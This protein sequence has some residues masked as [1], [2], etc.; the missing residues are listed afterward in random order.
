MK[1]EV[2]GEQEGT[3]E[4]NP[5]AEGSGA[6]DGDARVEPVASGG[7]AA[8][9]LHV[10]E[11][12]G[13]PPAQE[14]L[15]ED[16]TEAGAVA[17][18][19]QPASLE[20]AAEVEPT[21]ETAAL[22]EEGAMASAGALICT[23]VLPP[24]EEAEEAP[25]APAAVPPLPQSPDA[26]PA[27]EKA[28]AATEHEQPEAAPGVRSLLEALAPARE[29]ARE[30]GLTLSAKPG[31][32]AVPIVPAASAEVAPPSLPEN[33]S[34]QPE[35]EAG[36]SSAAATAS[37]PVVPEEEGIDWAAVD[38]EKLETEAI[39]ASPGQAVAEPAD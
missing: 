31:S 3:G 4:Q 8:A 23:E 29:R 30:L 7:A 14:L 20:R 37:A 12:A 24:A 17:T 6:G 27:A 33:G 21:T 18:E 22:Q 19:A 15:Q 9:E 36:S 1:T 26:E 25:V 34:Q 2:R 16:A 13:T 39:M 11:S 32:P 35:E 28:P 38:C 5:P 10:P